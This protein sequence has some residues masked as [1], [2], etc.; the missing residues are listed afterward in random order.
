VICAEVQSNSADFAKSYKELVK[1]RINL[2]KAGE[3]FE[4]K[5]LSYSNSLTSYYVVEEDMNLLK[6]KLEEVSLAVS[7]PPIR[8][9]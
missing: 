4:K 1:V 9:Q 5:M 6:K 8:N 3:T 7:R 2:K